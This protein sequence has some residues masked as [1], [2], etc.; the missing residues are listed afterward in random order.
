MDGS[1]IE[2][3]FFILKFIAYEIVTGKLPFQEIDTSINDIR[4]ALDKGYCPTFPKY[5]PKKMQQMI[6][7]C[8]SPKPEKRPSFDVIYHELTSDF[9]CY[10]YNLNQEEITSYIEMLEIES[11]DSKNS[12]SIIDEKESTANDEFILALQKIFENKNDHNLKQVIPL[13]KASSE[14]GNSYSSF[15]TILW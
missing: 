1:F 2:L 14:K 9:L 11:E 6:S 8:W 3:S 7:L 15:W 5:V 12:F 13:L 4:N 10:G